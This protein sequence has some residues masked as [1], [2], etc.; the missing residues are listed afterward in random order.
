M[1]ELRGQHDLRH[2]QDRLPASR[3]HAADRSNI[4]LRLAR[5]ADSVNEGDGEAVFVDVFVDAL[6]RFALLVV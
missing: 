2:E 5:A 4:D 6:K 3:H 1:N